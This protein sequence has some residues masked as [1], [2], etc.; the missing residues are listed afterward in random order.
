MFRLR[1]IPPVFCFGKTNFLPPSDEGGVNEVDGGREEQ[2]I[3]T[4]NIA[5]KNLTHISPSVSAT[6]NSCILYSSIA[7]PPPS[8]DGGIRLVQILTFLSV[9]T[10]FEPH[11]LS[12]VSTIQKM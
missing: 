6:K 8:S 5:I 7:E 11:S 3:Y 4:N 1:W 9:K 10:S 2:T 12:V